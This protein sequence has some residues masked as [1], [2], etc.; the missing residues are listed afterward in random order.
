MKSI[1]NLLAILATISITSC[2]EKIDIGVDANANIGFQ[3]AGVYVEVSLGNGSGYYYDQ[4]AYQSYVWGPSGSAPRNN[5]TVV[6]IFSKPL[7]QTAIA[8]FDQNGRPIGRA[9]CTSGTWQQMNQMFLF[10]QNWNYNLKPCKVLVEWD[11][12]PFTYGEW[13][14]KIIG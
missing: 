3:V 13:S 4:N 8:V 12:R 9:S 2:G 10:L 1:K 11:P 5:I 6:Y 7:D 14:G